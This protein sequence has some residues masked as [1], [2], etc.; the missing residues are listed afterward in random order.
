MYAKKITLKSV[1]DKTQITISKVR[2]LHGALN[3]DWVAG[4]LAGH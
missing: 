2:Y 4:S 1:T 3:Y